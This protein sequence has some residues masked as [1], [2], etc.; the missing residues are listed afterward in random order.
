MVLVITKK[1]PVG[2][3]TDPGD[4]LHTYRCRDKGAGSL[5]DEVGYSAPF[6]KSIGSA[7]R[8]K[9][10]QEGRENDQAKNEE[11]KAKLS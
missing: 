8:Y 1:C 3:Y 2:P 7:D 10:E 5:P 11:A 9:E 4:T 6:E